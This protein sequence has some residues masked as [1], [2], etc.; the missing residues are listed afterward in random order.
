MTLAQTWPS[1][2]GRKRTHARDSKA[3][4]LTGEESGGAP[5]STLPART[6]LLP[7]A[8]AEEHQRSRIGQ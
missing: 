4:P 5:P 1:A 6:T 2:M 8:T 3:A 7:L